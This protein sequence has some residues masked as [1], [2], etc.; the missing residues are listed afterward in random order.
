[1]KQVREATNQLETDAIETRIQYVTHSLSLTNIISLIFVN[2]SVTSSTMSYVLD[3]VLQNLYFYYDSRVCKTYKGCR[4][5]GFVIT[6][7][8]DYMTNEHALIGNEEGQLQ[9]I[10][11][12]TA[13]TIRQMNGHTREINCIVYC[14]ELSMVITGSHDN[15]ARVWNVATGECVHVLKGHTGYVMCAAVQGTTYVKCTLQIGC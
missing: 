5:L 11:P 4:V 12:E 9:L 6:A 15:T 1:M 8:P 2:F 13:L 3:F 14:S 7:I 10:E